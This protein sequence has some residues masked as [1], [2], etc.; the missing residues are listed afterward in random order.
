MG[1]WGPKLNWT[2]QRKEKLPSNRPSESL[3]WFAN[4][5]F[6]RNSLQPWLPCYPPYSFSTRILFCRKS[7]TPVICTLSG[8]S[9]CLLSPRSPHFILCVSSPSWRRVLSPTD[10]LLLAQMLCRCPVICN[11][12]CS[13]VF[14][15][16]WGSEHSRLSELLPGP[17][18]CEVS[19]LSKISV[20]W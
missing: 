1:T 13:W 10:R 3:S 7:V 12:Y 6:T 9:F 14:L 20:K 17:C 15:L 11:V 18:V 16:A 2:S 8:V 5:T 19:N 4:S